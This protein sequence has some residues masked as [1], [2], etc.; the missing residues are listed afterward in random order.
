MLKTFNFLKK[1]FYF[2]S[3]FII[4]FIYFCYFI[5]SYQISFLNNYAYQELFLNYEGGFVRRGLIGSIF[6]KIH[7]LTNISPEI[8]FPTLM[9]IIH[10]FCALCLFLILKKYKNYNLINLVILFSPSLLLFSIYDFNM[11]FVKDIFVK[12]AI[13]FHGILVVNFFSNKSLYNVVL[14]YFLLPYISFV[15]IFIHEYQLFFFSVHF[16]FSLIILKKE[17]IYKTYL[18]YFFICLLVLVLFTGDKYI[19]EEINNSLL[20]FN[21]KIHSQLSGGILWYLGGWYKWHLYYFGYKDFFMFFMSFILSLWIF[22]YFFQNLINKKILLM[23]FKSQYAYLFFLIPSL[24]IFIA[25]DHGRNFSLLSI[26]LVVFYLVLNINYNLLNKK[27]NEILSNFSHLNFFIIFIF[28]YIFMWRLPQDAGFGGKEQIN[29]IFKGSLFS[30]FKEFIK[31]LYFFI[32]QN[33]VD[34]PEIKL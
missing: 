23:N 27:Y 30:E 29:T 15:T 10:S 11:F 18:F 28:L 3:I 19:L 26:H 4:S 20:K 24:G 32:D 13:L 14:K 9:I 5:K 16:L 2:L 17:T 7:K 8:F 34:L 21:I 25:T 31:Y 6:F 1:N 12:F 22:F 33:I